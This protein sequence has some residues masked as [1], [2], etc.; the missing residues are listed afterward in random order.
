MTDSSGLSTTQIAQN[1][2]AQVVALVRAELRLARAEVL[3]KARGIAVGAGL[4]AAAAT[5]LLFAAGVAVAAVVLGLSV[6]V[7]PWAAALITAAGLMLLA[8]P[9]VLIGRSM[10]RKAVPPVPRMTVQDVR[11]DLT[12]ITAAARRD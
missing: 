1:L 2:P 8:G 10:L 3:A 9:L 5:M 4:L 6:V 12:A 11:E 7:P